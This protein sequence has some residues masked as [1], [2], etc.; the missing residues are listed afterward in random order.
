MLNRN[1]ISYPINHELPNIPTSC[2]PYV[3]FYPALPDSSLIS[4]FK[5]V[6]DFLGKAIAAKV[7]KESAAKP[8]YSG[9]G[10]LML[11]PTYKHILWKIL[12]I[13]AVWFWKMAFSWHAN[14]PSNK[15]RGGGRKRNLS[16]RLPRMHKGEL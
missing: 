10:L 14:P 6:G 2:F 15:P 1:T 5:G 7:T 11:E 8:E 12:L 4:E 3:Q 13:G 16:P 9:N